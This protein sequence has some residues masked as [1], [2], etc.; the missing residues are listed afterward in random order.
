MPCPYSNQQLVLKVLPKQ[1]KRSWPWNQY[2]HWTHLIEASRSCS[3]PWPPHLPF[4]SRRQIPSMIWVPD[5]TTFWRLPHC[6]FSCFEKNG[7]VHL[8]FFHFLQCTTRV[9]VIRLYVRR[10]ARALSEWRMMPLLSILDFAISCH[11]LDW[12]GPGPGAFRLVS[13]S[14]S[15]DIH[16]DPGEPRLMSPMKLDHRCFCPT[17]NLAECHLVN[18][19]LV[20]II[21]WIAIGDHVLLLLDD[22]ANV[23][24]EL[25][26]VPLDGTSW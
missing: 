3:L 6:T 23:V 1:R 11:T 13:R 19:D 12:M 14:G 8:P 20:P 15:R 9:C 18:L 2:F 26:D 10:Y 21:S 24:L 22:L 4:L 25:V 16:K 5:L 17:F 7:F